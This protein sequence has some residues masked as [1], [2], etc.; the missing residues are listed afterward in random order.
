VLGEYFCLTILTDTVT[1]DAPVMAV[2][3][4]VEML[5]AP[6]AAILDHDFIRE[7]NQAD[8]LRSA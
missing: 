4:I 8:L 1:D 7:S 5:L 3:A 6:S 2:V